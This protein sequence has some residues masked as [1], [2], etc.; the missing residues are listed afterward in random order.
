M[1]QEKTGRWCP[2]PVTPF[3]TKSAVCI[4]YRGVNRPNA[5]V[6]T[7]TTKYHKSLRVLP[8]L[9]GLCGVSL[10][11]P[12]RPTRTQADTQVYHHVAMGRAA[13]SS[14]PLTTTQHRSRLYHINTSLTELVFVYLCSICT[15]CRLN[16]CNAF[17]CFL[18]LLWC[19]SLQINVGL[20]RLAVVF[21]LWL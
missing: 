4:T 18:R 16:I 15:F 20:L 13:N 14:G 5:E 9:T 3:T 21:V 11:W 17:V 7:V 2:A 12:K 19:S 6:E 10:Q 1:R 8:S